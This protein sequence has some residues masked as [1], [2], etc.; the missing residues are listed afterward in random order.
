MRL[1]F[2]VFD[3][4][5]SKRLPVIDADTGKE[6]GYI[7][8]NGTGMYSGGGIDISLFD[9][10]YRT[11]VT[12]YEAV[13]GFVMGVESVLNRMTSTDDGHC[14]LEPEL[15]RTKKDSAPSQPENSGDRATSHPP[16]SGALADFSGV[17]D[18]LQPTLRG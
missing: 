11:T 5:S 1:K 14:R 4:R 10:K 12:R 3:G 16:S 15:Q 8:A 18:Q 2:K 6:V 17:R 7:K 13:L 9:G